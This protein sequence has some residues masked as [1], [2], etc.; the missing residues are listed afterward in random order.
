MTWE[1]RELRA[2]CTEHNHSPAPFTRGAAAR[3]HACC[4]GPP[5]PCPGPAAFTAQPVGPRCRRGAGERGMAVH[6]LQLAASCHPP[7]PAPH[8]HRLW[9][10]HEFMPSKAPWQAAAASL[11]LACCC[12]SPRLLLQLGCLKLKPTSEAHPLC[13]CKS[14][15]RHAPHRR[16]LYFLAC[17]GSPLWG[18][19]TSVDTSPVAAQSSC[20]RGRAPT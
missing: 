8:P 20:S 14:A 3:R 2:T 6:A 15:T 13:I 1:R 18:P 10:E 19:L 16:F 7:P 5:A 11:T 9:H 17:P 4:S 12:C